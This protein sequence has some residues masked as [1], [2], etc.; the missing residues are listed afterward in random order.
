MVIEYE[1]VQ[2]DLGS[3]F[4]LLHHKNVLPTKYVW[5]YHYHPEV[6]LVC[7]VKGSGVRHVGHHMSRYEDGDLI[8]V[9]S[10]LPHSGFGLDASTPHEEIVIQLPE[11]ILLN[12]IENY[13]ELGSCQGLL[14]RAQYG[15]SFHGAT[16]QKAKKLMLELLNVPVQNRIFVV[17][18]IFQLLSN[19]SDYTL[20]NNKLLPTKQL[21]H[22]KS[23]LETIFTYVE[24]NYAEH[25]SI[26][27]IASRV[28]LTIPSFS[29]FFK[30]TMSITFTEFVNNYR[31]RKS[32]YYLREGKSVT[33]T[34]NLCGYNS[35][36]YF[37]RVFKRQMGS[38]PKRYVA[39]VQ[40][41]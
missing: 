37:N 38:S 3:S 16:Y 21:L 18:Q 2:K 41:I 9:G 7:I 22:V 26:E 40:I 23:R 8:L 10:N 35:L 5:Q 15:I 33:E 31:V 27:E 25:L 39:D 30:K 14:E 1:I 32:C 20:L 34:C 6:E 28:G 12:G 29:A 11:S 36:S 19:S 4:R 17:L 13:V 24:E